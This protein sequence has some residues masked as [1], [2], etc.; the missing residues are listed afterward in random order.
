MRAAEYVAERAQYSEACLLSQGDN[1]P[2]AV[3]DVT[4]PE[5]EVAAGYEPIRVECNEK[6]TPGGDC[7]ALMNRLAGLIAFGMRP[8]FE[9]FSA[10][11][12]WSSNSVILGSG[13][14][15]P[16]ILRA[17]T[18]HAYTGQHPLLGVVFAPTD[19]TRVPVNALYNADWAAALAHMVLRQAELPT[20]VWIT[21][22]ERPADQ[23]RA[24]GRPGR[25]SPLGGS[26][27]TSGGSVPSGSVP[28]DEHGGN[29]PGTSTPSSVP[30]RCGHYWMGSSA[31]EPWFGLS[32]MRDVNCS[33]ANVS[34]ADQLFNGSSPVLTENCA[35]DLFLDGVLHGFDADC[36][37][38][39]DY[40]L[41][42]GWQVWVFLAFSVAVAAVA[43]YVV[44]LVLTK[45]AESLVRGVVHELRPVF[46]RLYQLCAECE[47]RGEPPELILH[48]S[49]S[50]FMLIETSLKGELHANF[51]ALGCG[52]QGALAQ[53]AY[54]VATAWP[55]HAFTLGSV[56]YSQGLTNALTGA[57]CVHYT[58]HALFAI[59]YYSRSLPF[60]LLGGRLLRAYLLLSRSYLLLALFTQV[61]VLLWMLS[62]VSFN[63]E[64]VANTIVYS[65]S[66]L[67]LVYN[68]VHSASS[69][70]KLQQ[71]VMAQLSPEQARVAQRVYCTAASCSTT[72]A[73]VLECASSRAERATLADDASAASVCAAA[74]ASE[75][76]VASRAV[77]ASKEGL[78]AAG[79]AMEAAGALRSAEVVDAR[80][81]RRVAQA[82]DEASAVSDEAHAA[83]EQGARL[84]GEAQRMSARAEQALMRLEM[85]ARDIRRVLLCGGATLVGAAL[86]LIFGSIL[87]NRG[88]S[89]DTS[90]VMERALG[91]FAV[92]ATKVSTSKALNKAKASVDGMDAD[93]VELASRKE[94]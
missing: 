45:K 1:F 78:E 38:E 41:D 22:K 80:A 54:V 62:A 6:M 43:T 94:M 40:A 8:G 52:V 91:P 26:G 66:F 13:L 49:F 9:P 84:A 36:D 47:A 58:N 73:R 4:W 85:T 82:Y 37:Y 28:S 53:A 7:Y 74:S 2:L 18:F 33:A 46:P 88:S 61:F 10:T 31:D 3:F 72:A 35:I 55:L 83:I 12:L 77:S 19:L 29:R 56:G 16:A 5:E 23:A 17:L 44:A 25:R 63:A 75:G 20:D 27:G 71:V 81:T 87:W 86:L 59:G 48:S 76:S 51:E 64:Y 69:L 65:L 30:I 32:A 42:S 89:S 79:A 34:L 50:L 11:F 57:V 68:V 15:P 92:L 21:G 60:T 67:A 90:Y 14:L 39:S 93:A 24:A 70:A